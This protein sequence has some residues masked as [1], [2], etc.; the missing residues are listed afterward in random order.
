MSHPLLPGQKTNGT[1]QIVNK[2]GK[3]R[4]KGGTK[5]I[6]AFLKT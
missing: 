5:D 4:R 3:K 1:V 2:L 6:V